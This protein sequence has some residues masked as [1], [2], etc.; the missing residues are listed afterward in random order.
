[1]IW[2]GQASGIDSGQTTL[3]SFYQQQNLFI[4][5]KLF[6]YQKKFYLDH[7]VLFIGNHVGFIYWYQKMSSDYCKRKLHMYIHIL[8]FEECQQWI[9]GRCIWDTWVF[10][11]C[12]ALMRIWNITCAITLIRITK[13]MRIWNIFRIF[14]S[15]RVMQNLYF[16][17]VENAKYM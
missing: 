12:A 3:S 4:F 9:Y 10:Y 8:K 13:W 11:F 14:V 17:Q 15:H 6:L 7:M 16:V 5:L 2:K 1:V